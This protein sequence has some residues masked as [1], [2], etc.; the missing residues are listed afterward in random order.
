MPAICATR[1][2]AVF[3]GNVPALRPSGTYPRRKSRHARQ[4]LE[5]WYN[6]DMDVAADPG[7]VRSLDAMWHAYRVSRSSA[8]T[9]VEIR[10][11]VVRDMLNARYS[12]STRGQFLS[13]DPLFVGDPRQQTLTD[14]QS[15]NSYSYSDDNPITKSDPSGRCG[16]VCIVGSA[17]Y[18]GAIASDVGIDVYN[19]VRDPSVP[20]YS[21]L[22]PRG[23]DAAFRYNRDAWSSVAVA[24]SALAGEDL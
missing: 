6:S 9:L 10:T 4:A 8:Q 18:V 11:S 20:W 15:L 14:P 3:G 7:H 5:L 12:D 1:S 2:L 16:T 24:E 23:D 17:A 13:Q 19:N 21:V 22:T